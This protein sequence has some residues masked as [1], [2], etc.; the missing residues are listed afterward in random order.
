MEKTI[1]PTGF[2]TWFKILAP[3]EGMLADRPISQ[4]KGGLTM[5]GITFA[6]FKR[7]AK[8]ILGIEP[9]DANLRA[10]TAEQAKKITYE[11][12]WLA[13]GVNQ[14]LPEYRTLVA[15]SL[16]LGGG[17]PSLGYSNISALNK[18]KPTITV[19]ATNRLNY[20]KKLHNWESNKNGWT[21]RLENMSGNVVKF[22]K[23][24]LTSVFLLLI[25]AV[26]F[27]TFKN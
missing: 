20:L 14:A 9:T 15:D 10:L 5:R 26:V 3:S 21:T 24:N 17:V 19:I 6:T 4:D 12:Y 18:A 27:I 7:V 8:P 13:R 1:Y 23:E 2:E 16:F 11:E 25:L 22:S